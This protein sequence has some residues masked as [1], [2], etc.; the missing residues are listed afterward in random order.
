DRLLTTEGLLIQLIEE[1]AARPL[2]A[3]DGFYLAIDEAQKA[4]ALFERIKAIYDAHKEKIHII[5]TGSSA[6]AIHDPAAE[7]LAGRARILNLHPFCLSEGFAHSR[8]ENPTTDPQLIS[9]MLTG[10]FTPDDYQAFVEN[11]RWHADL[12]RKW[13]Q[14]HLRFPLFPEPANHPQPEAWIRDYLATYIEKDVQSLATVGNISL[15][16]ESIRQIAARVGSTLKWETMAQEIGTTSGTLRRYVGLMEETFNLIRLGAFAVNPTKRV[17]K[18][19]KL[20][21]SDPGLLWGLRGYEDLR[22]LEASGMLGSYMELL[23]VNEI[24][25]WCSFESTAP[26]L[27]F[28]HK[29]GVSEVDLV[30]SNRGYHIPFEIKL[31]TQYK[32]AWLR[33]LDA[34]D[35][36]HR[37]NSLEI[38]YRFILHMGEPA[39]LDSRTYLLP[40][41]MFA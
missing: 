29:T 16:R 33:G 18:A 12:K 37:P 13:V 30:V 34:F 15:F 36:D 7:T 6:L 35:A 39:I 19:P 23:A 26:L 28:W 11:G 14:E 32:P 17:V 1:S 22:L 31:G 41:W 27:R 24:A 5:L 25:K 8:G 38:P 10:Q 9:R 3:I 2:S 40:L 4:P 20:V 21:L